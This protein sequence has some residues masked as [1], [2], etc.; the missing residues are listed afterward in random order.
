MFYIM[1]FPFLSAQIQFFMSLG[2]TKSAFCCELLEITAIVIMLYA[3]EKK[4]V[5]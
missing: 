3:R 1:S 2:Q 4:S 5:I